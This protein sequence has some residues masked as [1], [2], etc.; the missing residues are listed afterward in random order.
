MSE[1]SETITA[2][3]AS[4]TPEQA[5]DDLHEIGHTIESLPELAEKAG[6]SGDALDTVNQVT[7]EL[8]DAFGTLDG[9][10]HGGEAVEVEDVSAEVAEQIDKLRSVR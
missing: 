3:F 10:L 5:H 9:S 1:T 6:L 2:A 4:G 7:E 8:M